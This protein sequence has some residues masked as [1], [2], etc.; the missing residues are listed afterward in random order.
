M[1][2][3]TEPEVQAEP[4]TDDINVQLEEAR[5]QQEPDFDPLHTRES[6]MARYDAITRAIGNSG[7][8]PG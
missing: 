3:Q 7:P 6:L 4:T 8:T 5:E 2:K 1:Q